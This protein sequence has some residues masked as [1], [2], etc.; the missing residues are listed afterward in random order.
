MKQLANNQVLSKSGRVDTVTT[1]LIQPT[2]GSV[3]AQ[4]YI[5][6]AWADMKTFSENEAVD[7]SIKSDVQWRFTIP[8]GSSVYYYI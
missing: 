8:S 4:V 2:G 3:T 1:F 5:D 6:N 7:I